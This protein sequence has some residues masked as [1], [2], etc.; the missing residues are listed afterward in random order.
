MPWDPNA[1]AD[2]ARAIMSAQLTVLESQ[3]L[4]NAI[5][6]WVAGAGTDSQAFP[7]PNGQGSV[8]VHTTNGN[9]VQVDYSGW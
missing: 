5:N 4:N 2:L 6:A 9:V 3:N 7:M 1:A 8:T